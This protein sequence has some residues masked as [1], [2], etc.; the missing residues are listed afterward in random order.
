MNSLQVSAI[1]KVD[2]GLRRPSN[3]DAVIAYQPPTSELI[4]SH[5]ILIG[6]ADGVGSS[7][8][9][10]EASQHGLDQ[11]VQL[12]YSQSDGLPL[13]VRLLKALEQTNQYIRTKYPN[14]ASTLTIGVILNDKLHIVHIGDSRGYLIRG[15]DCRQITED[16]VK[17]IPNSKKTLLARAMGQRDVVVGEYYQETLQPNDFIILLTDGA[18]R[19]LDTSDLVRICNFTVDKQKIVDSIIAESK[20]GGGI[21]NIGVALAKIHHPNANITT[22]I[23]PG[24]DT[25]DVESSKAPIETIDNPDL[26]SESKKN[27]PNYIRLLLSVIF[28]LGKS[29]V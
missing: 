16:H 4:K 14:G 17:L 9:G 7:A 12:Y 27:K 18:T 1:A 19:Y 26:E 22:I 29:V 24:L 15:Q 11:C 13:R 21:D 25:V 23:E 10:K 8:Q 6:V 2:I 5:G 20:S 3:E 28:V